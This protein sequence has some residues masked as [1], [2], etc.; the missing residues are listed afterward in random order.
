MPLP[1][2]SPPVSNLSGSWV[3]VSE[4]PQWPGPPGASETILPFGSRAA[5]PGPEPSLWTSARW[6]VR[7]QELWASGVCPIHA[8]SRS[9][10]QPPHRGGL[11]VLPRNPPCLR[12]RASWGHVIEFRLGDRLPRPPLRL[13][14]LEA[15]P[16]TSEPGLSL[17]AT[18]R[19]PAT[20]KRG[21][22]VGLGFV[23]FFFPASFLIEKKTLACIYMFF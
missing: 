1:A 14:P 17:Q 16:R 7:G 23:F 20:W 10:F 12:D 13:V 19:P 5:C 15:G 11:S 6:P 2:C 9:S 22:P 18:R 4:R 21:V 3:V 8:D